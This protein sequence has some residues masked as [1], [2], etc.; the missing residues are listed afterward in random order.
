[1]KALPPQFDESL[2][3]DGLA[4]HYNF[5]AEDIGYRPWGMGSYHWLA[6][7]KSGDLF[8]TLDM[9]DRGGPA[10]SAVAYRNLKA[11]YD[12]AWSL[13][14]QYGLEF[15]HPPILSTT[16]RTTVQISPRFSLSATRMLDGLSGTSDDP[17]DARTTEV[18]TELLSRLQG[19]TPLV[20]GIARTDDLDFT[21]RENLLWMLRQPAESWNGGPYSR[22]AHDL[23]T[24]NVS[25]I[26]A[27]I[28]AYD[29]LAAKLAPTRER[30]VVT[31]GDPHPGNLLRVGDRHLMIDWDMAF[32]APPERDLRW[33]DPAAP[34]LS[35]DA[36]EF[37][38]QRYVLDDL[39][40]FAARLFNPHERTLDTAHARQR[41]DLRVESAVEMGA[42]S[43]RTAG[44]A[45][46]M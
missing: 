16:N 27:S 45:W 5:K 38:S 10:T 35:A 22:E 34:G 37:Y 17:F 2:V 26:V 32:I 8:V 18:M 42:A 28:R 14:H 3:A 19:A 4:Q 25:E 9:L 15:V 29:R 20:G 13:R 41:L 31:H 11:S 30:W 33:L 12:T 7:S 43:S 21:G 36:V 46:A 6:T 1:M 44:E 39:S 24:A 40:I 23:L